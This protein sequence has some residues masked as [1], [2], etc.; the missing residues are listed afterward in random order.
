LS[1]LLLLQ[2][3]RFLQEDTIVFNRGDQAET[4]CVVISGEVMA[5]LVSENG[6]GNIL[7]TLKSSEGFGE[8]ALLTGEPRSAFIYNIDVCRE[9]DIAAT[10]PGFKGLY[11]FLKCKNNY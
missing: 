2:N 10:Q 3:N 1:K 6:K 7:T 11:L 4:Y 9:F 8:M 5:Y